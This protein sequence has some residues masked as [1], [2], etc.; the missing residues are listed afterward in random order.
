M[1][2]FKLLY[3]AINTV[4]LTH[5]IAALADDNTNGI[6]GRASSVVDNT[7]NLDLDHVLSGFIKAGTTPTAGRTIELWAWG[8][9]QIVGG[10]PS[11]PDG[12]TGSDT[13]KSFTSRNILQASLYPVQT[14]VV[15]ATTG[16]C[17]P[18]SRCPLL[19][20]LDRCLPIGVCSR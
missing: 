6:A 10:T 20:S 19:R 15:D 13:N 4:A 3:P 17:T 8:Y 12:I 14:I 7:A 2:I 9:T 1:A 18:S 16:T 5:N 11:Y